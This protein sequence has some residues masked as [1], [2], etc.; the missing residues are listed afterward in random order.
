M[1]YLTTLSVAQIMYYG[2]VSHVT[3]RT[4]MASLQTS[5]VVVA[6]LSFTIES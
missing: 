1:V 2:M 3:R 6:L 5:E 4:H